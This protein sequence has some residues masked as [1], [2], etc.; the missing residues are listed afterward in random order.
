MTSVQ[1]ELGVKLQIEVETFRP[2]PH[3]FDARQASDS[4]L[5]RHGFPRRPVEDERAME[6]YDA[7]LR[8]LEGKLHYIVPT[9]TTRVDKRHRPLERVEEG[10][11]TSS[12]WSG[13]VQYASAGNAFRWVEGNWTIPNVYPPTQNAWYY[14]SSWIGIDGDGSNDVCQA[15]IECEVF[16]SGSSIIRNI[17]PWFEWY[18]DF[19]H[20]ITNFPV[21]AGDEITCVICTGGAGAT[22]ASIYFT[23]VSSGAATSLSMTAPPANQNWNGHLEGNCAEWVVERPEVG[24]SLANLADYGSV[25]FFNAEAYDGSQTLN[26]GQGDD[27][28]MYN[29]ST[30]ISDGVLDAPTLV[31]CLYKGPEP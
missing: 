31:Q 8:R 1:E 14:C 11:E 4:D 16:Q 23:N 2:P 19:E 20:P 10:Q 24:G 28:D 6:R 7:V 30:I 25:V 5:V 17:Y 13:G 15:G 12:N 22:S 26:G 29:G 9:F 3:R 21:S 27:M 18:P